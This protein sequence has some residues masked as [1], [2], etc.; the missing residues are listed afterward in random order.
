[1]A[2]LEGLSEVL[3]NLERVVKQISDDAAKKALDEQGDRLVVD[4]VANTPVLTG[5]AA[6]SVV[7][8]KATPA[9]VVITAGGS[10]AIYFPLIEFGGTH[11]RQP[12]APVRRALEKRRM[13]L[14]DETKASIRKSVPELK[15]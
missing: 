14:V 10:G 15:G 13:V 3:D 11:N 9:E 4:I 2:I 6:G 12:A 5:S 8:G 1:M 7:K